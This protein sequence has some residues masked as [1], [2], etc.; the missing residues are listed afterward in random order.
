MALCISGLERLIEFDLGLAYWHQQSDTD[1]WVVD[2]VPSVP[3]VTGSILAAAR[4]TR[5][6]DC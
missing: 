3:A 1:C 6:P 4:S 5:L 2:V